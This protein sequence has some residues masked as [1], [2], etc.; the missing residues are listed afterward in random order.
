MKASLAK[1][2]PRR[3]R[4]VSLL[5]VALLSPGCASVDS[6]PFRQFASSLQALREGSDAQ[7]GAAANASREELIQKVATGKISTTDLQL[8]FDASSLGASYGFADGEPDFVKLNHFRHGLDA[9]NR[10]MIDYA[11]SLAI[12]SG[13]G[14]AGDVLPTSAQFEQLA[15]NLNAN[16]ATAAAALHLKVDPDRRGLLSATAV[17]LFQA[18][19][20][21]KRRGYLVE[22]ISEVQPRVD[23]FAIKTRQAIHVLATMLETDYAK[24]IQPLMEARP[25][26]AR[27]I[28]ALNETTQATFATLSSLSSGYGALGAAHRDL[29]AAASR[30]PVGFAGLVALAEEAARLRNLVARLRE[31]N[32]AA[33]TTPPSLR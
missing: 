30:K 28:L 3:R 15:E 19:I 7:A 12:L 6:G 9:L 33:A 16:A 5:G 31:A 13:G 22:A 10:A 2:H 27:P 17:R 29:M 1:I 21:K 25:A 20:E 11:E 32:A 8:T 4:L 18:Y 26:D 24:K 14:K 23:E